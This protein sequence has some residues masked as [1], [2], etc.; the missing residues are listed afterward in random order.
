MQ[1][2][3]RTLCLLLAL[4]GCLLPAPMATPPALAS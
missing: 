2:F 3:A 4:L 1:P